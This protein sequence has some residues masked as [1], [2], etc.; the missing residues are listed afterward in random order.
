MQSDPHAPSVKDRSNRPPFRGHILFLEH[1]PHRC[2]RPRAAVENERTSSKPERSRVRQPQLVRTH[3]NRIFT[4]LRADR[5][6]ARCHQNCAMMNQTSDQ[7]FEDHQLELDAPGSLT[8][9]IRARRSFR[10]S[11][12]TPAHSRNVV[13]FSRQTR[14]INRPCRRAWVA[15]TRARARRC[16]I[17]RLVPDKALH[18]APRRTQSLITFEEKAD[19]R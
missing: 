18:L 19:L 13:R 1:A 17:S 5:E 9:G 10:A 8:R 11:H 14:D 6:T 4:A 16:P 15:R 2:Y 7:A 12:A 3:A